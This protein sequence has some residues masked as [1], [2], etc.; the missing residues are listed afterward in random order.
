MNELCE[1]KLICSECT[2]SDYYY[3][4]IEKAADELGLQYTLE[5]LTDEDQMAKH[6]V[7][8]RCLLA[9]CP[10]CEALNQAGFSS[11]S[12]MWVPAMLIN[13]QIAAHSRVPA[14]DEIKAIL[15]AFC[16]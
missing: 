3:E 4:L 5:K 10:G 11:D 16:Q 2:R 15:L 6:G 14:K 7:S 9:Y 8:V 13:G 1:I 12:E